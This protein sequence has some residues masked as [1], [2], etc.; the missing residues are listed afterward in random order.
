MSWENMGGKMHPVKE[1]NEDQT[2]TNFKS[3][4]KLADIKSI[5]SVHLKN[6]QLKKVIQVD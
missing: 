2:Q 1:L 4:T 6:T 5:D 3:S